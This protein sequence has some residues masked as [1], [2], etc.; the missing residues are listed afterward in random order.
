MGIY[1]YNALNFS[2]LRIFEPGN[3]A[4]ANRK[5]RMCFIHHETL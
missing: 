5:H 4:G 3:S 1:S 2:V